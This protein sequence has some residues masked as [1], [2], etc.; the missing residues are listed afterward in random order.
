METNF[1]YRILNLVM[2]LK[3]IYFEPKKIYIAHKI[4][5]ENNDNGHENS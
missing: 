4:D 3:E 1:C 5:Q 2:F